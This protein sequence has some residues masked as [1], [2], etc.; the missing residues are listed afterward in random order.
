MFWARLGTGAEFAVSRDARAGANTVQHNVGCFSFFVFWG[1]RNICKRLL[2]ISSARIFVGRR[3]CSGLA[4]YMLGVL[5]V[6]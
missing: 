6:S 5:R 3:A 2:R 4:K 1:L